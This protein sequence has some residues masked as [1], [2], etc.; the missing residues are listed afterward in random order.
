VR[1]TQNH[2]LV[3]MNLED[4]RRKQYENEKEKKI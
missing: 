3:R 2:A 1:T 4:K